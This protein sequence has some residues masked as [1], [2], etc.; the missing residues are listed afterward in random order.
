MR[1]NIEIA[2]RG[3]NLVCGPLIKRP[4]ELALITRPLGQLVL[5]LIV[6]ENMKFVIGCLTTWLLLNCSLRGDAQGLR[7]LAQGVGEGPDP[8]HLLQLKALALFP[9]LSLLL[10][11]APFKKV[12]EV[13]TGAH[14]P[15]P[16][17]WLFLATSSSKGQSFAGRLGPASGSLAHRQ[18]RANSSQVKTRLSSS[19]SCWLRNLA[20][21]SA[22]SSSSC[23][24]SFTK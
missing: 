18:L 17:H 12:L 7:G 9:T 10:H 8:P 22:N 2:I 19:C 5:K 24:D 21:A 1:Y 20:R 3:S 15:R 14:Q 6:Q 4:L 16:S 11:K 23:A 13:M